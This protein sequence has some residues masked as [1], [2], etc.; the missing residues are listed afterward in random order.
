MANK[1]R[2]GLIGASVSGTWSSRSHLPAVR[3]SGDVELVAVC[4]TKADSAEA[5]GSPL[6]TASMV[7]AE[8]IKVPARRDAPWG[9]A[10]EPSTP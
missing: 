7:T 10:A 9:P 5:A 3:A 4:T 2:L 1:V 6:V 8:G